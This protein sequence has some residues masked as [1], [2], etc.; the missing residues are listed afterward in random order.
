MELYEG[1]VPLGHRQG[2]KEHA[3]E[4]PGVLLVEGHTA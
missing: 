1:L 4:P 2:Q 3:P